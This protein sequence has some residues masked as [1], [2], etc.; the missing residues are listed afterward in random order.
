[1]QTQTQQKAY[2]KNYRLTFC[3]I[4]DVI[5]AGQGPV[6]S[7]NEQEDNLLSRLALSSIEIIPENPFPLLQGRVF[8]SAEL[9]LF[10]QSRVAIRDGSD[11]IKHDPKFSKSDDLLVS[12]LNFTAINVKLYYQQA[13]GG[14]TV[15]STMEL[16]TNFIMT[17]VRMFFILLSQMSKNTLMLWDTLP[18]DYYDISTEMKRESITICSNFGEEIGFGEIEPL[19]TPLDVLEEDRCRI[20]EN[21]KKQL[22][23][24]MKGAVNVTELQTFGILVYGETV[25]LSIMKFEDGR[26]KY[27]IFKT[28]VIPTTPNT[29]KHMEQ[30]L[31]FLLGFFDQMER[32]INGQRLEGTTQL[33]EEFKP[34]LRPTITFI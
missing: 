11:I 21:L 3:E 15:A 10:H 14:N 27:C 12:L 23:R 9:E 33:F 5:V 8:S 31:S 16:G 19:N 29:Y 32:S 17:Y 25:E 2:P 13:E 18:I 22:H 20:A 7:L 34:T 24:R 30:S 26:Y 6:C 1:M 4:Q 28:L